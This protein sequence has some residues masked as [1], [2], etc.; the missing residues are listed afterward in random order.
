MSS[1]VTDITNT[2]LPKYRSVSG[3]LLFL[4]LCVSIPKAVLK[5]IMQI[6]FLFFLRNF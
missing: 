3:I 1:A 5:T 2:T 6:Y 4:W